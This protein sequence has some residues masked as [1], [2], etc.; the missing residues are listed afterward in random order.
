MNNK[1][2]SNIQYIYTIQH[3]NK[4][5]QSNIRILV[6]YIH[7]LGSPHIRTNKVHGV[8]VNNRHWSLST[9][10]VS[11]SN[12]SIEWSS[13][14]ILWFFFVNKIK[15]LCIYKKHRNCNTHNTKFKYNSL[16]IIWIFNFQ[17]MAKCLLWYFFS[18]SY[19]S[20][21]STTFL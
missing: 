18:F 9:C 10:L 12:V 7:N 8:V 11:I 16:H 5:R 21:R 19:L 3:I 14:I 20:S 2:V 13:T 6:I 15:T 17:K 4:K 1:L